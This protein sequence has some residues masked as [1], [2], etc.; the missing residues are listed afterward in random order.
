MAALLGIDLEVVY[1]ARVGYIQTAP[2]GGIG[3][4]NHPFFR[5]R[6]KPDTELI[7]APVVGEDLLKPYRTRFGN[8][9]FNR[10]KGKIYDANSG[11]QL[12]EL[13]LEDYLADF[14]DIS[15]PAEA[16]VSDYPEK[17]KIETWTDRF[18]LFEAPSVDTNLVVPDTRQV[19][20]R[21]CVARHFIV[22][23]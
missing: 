22:P 19:Y 3:P 18:T 7:A 11:P 17:L 20:L 2:L 23:D 6:G 13:G 16:E 15:T 5:Y 21:H 8:H 4:C 1:I 10:Y 9:I 14:I 12:G